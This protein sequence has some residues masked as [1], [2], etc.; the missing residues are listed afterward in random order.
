MLKLKLKTSSAA[1][2]DPSSSDAAAESPAATPTIPTPVTAGG[3]K[4]KLKVSRASAVAAPD[5]EPAEAP[6]QKRKYTRKPKVDEN[7]EPLA[8]A[9]KPAAKASKK[10]PREENGDHPS[11]TSKRRSKPTAKAL[12]RDDAE[13]DELITAPPA[14]SAPAL[15]RPAPVRTQSMKISLKTGKVAP[16]QPS[17]SNTTMLR[18]KGHVGK[19]PARP[20]GVG[21]DSEAEDAEEDPAIENQFILRMQPGPDCDAL[22]KAIEDKTIGKKV[23]EGGCGIGF[24]MLDREGRRAM[25]YIKSRIYAATM[26]DLPCVIESLKSWNKKDWVKTADIC[27]LLLVLGPVKDEDE[28]KK[29]PLPPTIEPSSHQFAHG[30]TPPMHWVRKRRFR[31]RVSYRRIEEVEQTVDNLLEEDT[32]ASELGG[33]VEYQVLDADKLNASDTS[34]D[35]SSDDDASEDDEDDGMVHD[36]NGYVMPGIEGE[37]PIA[38][39][40][41]PQDLENQMM[42]ALDDEMFGDASGDH[43]HQL[44]ETPITATSHDVAMHALG[45]HDAAHH[46]PLPTT[47]TPRS[48]QTE[49]E[50][51]SADDDGSD[52]DES[53]EDAVVDEDALAVQ[54]EQEMAREEIKELEKEIQSAWEQHN[55]TTNI[56]FQKK[57]KQ[58]IERLE[59]DLNVKKTMLGEEVD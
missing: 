23:A 28:A 2:A 16:P 9:A 41:D 26:V 42:A 3:T 56:P 49:T 17:R 34:S 46:H 5:A 8:A 14:A 7:G 51:E 52:E 37:T 30:L 11:P 43:D 13:D 35:E 36:H 45:L 31:P 50:T 44:V 47:E 58:K 24:R 55:R 48:N 21:Y 33:K 53:D 39:A 54:R 59:T 27:Q 38:D 57:I 12:N 10:R 1:P 29:Y 18:L 32:A 22:R 6:K 4:L 20:P 40:L 25:V 19:P 15:S